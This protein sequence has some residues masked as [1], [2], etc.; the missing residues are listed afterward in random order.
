M[1]A[2]RGRRSR[3]DADTCNILCYSRPRGAYFLSLGGYLAAWGIY[4]SYL[5]FLMS[6]LAR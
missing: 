5:L 4:V 2:G 3:H 1:S 6:K